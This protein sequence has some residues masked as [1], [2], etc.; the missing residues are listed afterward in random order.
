MP[1]CTRACSAA[2]IEKMKQACR[3]V[4]VWEGGG[5]GGEGGRKGVAINASTHYN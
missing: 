4:C 5:R 1:V 2:L 3:R